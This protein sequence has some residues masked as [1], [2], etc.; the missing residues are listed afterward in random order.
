[1]PGTRKAGGL[2][3]GRG[4]GGLRFGE[5]VGTEAVGAWLGQALGDDQPSTG[6]ENPVKLTQ[7]GR[8]IRPV[9]GRADRPGHRDRPVG[10][11]QRLGR[12][13]QEHNV[14]PGPAG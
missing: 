10:H 12:P 8:D 14:A 13:L 2:R 1:M 4:F 5:P 7:A 6:R 9:M 11:W 3:P